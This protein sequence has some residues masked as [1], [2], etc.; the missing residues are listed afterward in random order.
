VE[1][2][3]GQG[4]WGWWS[5]TT[6]KNKKGGER[7]RGGQ[8]GRRFIQRNNVL[9]LRIATTEEKEKRGGG[10][11]LGK[12]K[13]VGE[14]PEKRMKTVRAPLDGCPEIVGEKRGSSE[15]K[16]QGKNNAGERK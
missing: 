10:G 6:K 1:K 7:G 4:G 13:H 15:N 14:S 5:A 16:T 9:E 12:G 3:K 2:K 8:V 11:N